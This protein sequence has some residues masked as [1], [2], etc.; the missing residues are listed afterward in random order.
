MGS[1]AWQ[2]TWCGKRVRHDLA[3]KQQN[4]TDKHPVRYLT[5][6]RPSPLGCSRGISNFSKFAHQL[7]VV[8]PPPVIE[9]HQKSPGTQ[10]RNLAATLEPG[11]SLSFQIPS[12]NQTS[13]VVRW[14]R[15]CQ[16]R[17]H[18][19]DP[20]FWKILHAMGQLSSCA[21]TTEAHIP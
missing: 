15:I 7:K 4:S 9:E 11:F 21:S 18:D 13:L 14:L 20:W 8:H 16:C 12:Q 5:T 10:A 2:A 17:G 3:T 1:G 6:P 19:F